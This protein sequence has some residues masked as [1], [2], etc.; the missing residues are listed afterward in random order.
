MRISC[1]HII[2]AVERG[3]D[4]V[5][6]GL[7]VSVAANPTSSVPEKLNAAVTKVAATP[8]KPAASGPGSCQF[9]PRTHGS[10]F[11]A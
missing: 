9:L 4:S 2:D 6:R 8:L 5:F 3:T 11:L 1:K 7:G 10:A